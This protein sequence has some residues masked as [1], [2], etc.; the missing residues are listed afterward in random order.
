M[1]SK[2]SKFLTLIPTALI[3]M[4]FVIA[5]HLCTFNF[6]SADN[7]HVSHTTHASVQNHD[8]I[9]ECCQNN[10]GSEIK[11]FVA[12]NTNRLILDNTLSQSSTFISL[13]SFSQKL[14]REVKS[15]IPPNQSL[16]NFLQPLLS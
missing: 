14:S 12:E 13:N 1:F 4:L 10:N 9:K 15:D 3:A 2:Q 11:T 7:S 6:A 8:V 16:Q 5:G